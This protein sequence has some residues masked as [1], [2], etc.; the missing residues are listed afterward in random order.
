MVTHI[1]HGG[2]RSPQT[3]TTCRGT[4]ASRHRS[5]AKLSPSRRTVVAVTA[6]FLTPTTK[7]APR[8]AP[9]TAIVHGRIAPIST[10]LSPIAE[11]RDS[12]TTTMLAATKHRNRG[13]H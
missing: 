6:R 13:R 5:S 2:L 10:L 1:L 4:T 12:R 11:K 7:T 8:A 3:F 9:T